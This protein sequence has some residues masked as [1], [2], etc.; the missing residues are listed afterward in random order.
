MKTIILT[1]AEFHHLKYIMNKNE[2][3]TPYASNAVALMNKKIREKLSPP[4]CIFCDTEE[5]TL[6]NGVCSVC[7]T[8]TTP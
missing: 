8:Q 1:D 6:T 3:A 4:T 2:H 5:R 7:L